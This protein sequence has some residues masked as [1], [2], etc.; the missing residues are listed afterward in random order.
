[1]MTRHE[2]DTNELL[3]HAGRGDQAAA[4]Q[5]LIRHRRRLR[6]MIAIRLDRRV[7]ARVDPS[8]VV[9]EALL[10]AARKLPEYLRLRPVPFYPWLRRIAWEHLVKTHERHL[11]AQKRSTRREQRLEAAFTDESAG[12][13]ANR[14]V[15]SGTSPSYRLLRSEQR[16]RV[17]AALAQL[18]EADR[19][20]LVLRYLE[21]LS[22]KEIAEV[23][24]M[25]LGAVKM[26][27][28]RALAKLSGLLGGELGRSE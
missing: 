8:D 25:Q 12:E 9:Q 14:L 6:Q 2:P 5:L 7:A 16:S 17:R 13:L 24:D 26:R 10:E 19:E 1:M 15:A 3:L 28:T 11:S 21:E 27:H 22:M 18:S 23:L 4:E 20:V